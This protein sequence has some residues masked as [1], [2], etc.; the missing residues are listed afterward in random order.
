MILLYYFN[1]GAK[2][3]RYKL[4]F[5]ILVAVLIFHV[6]PTAP[7]S[8]LDPGEPAGKIWV[9]KDRKFGTPVMTSYK[10]EA[11]YTGNGTWVH[12]WSNVYNKK[13]GLF[14]ITLGES[15][16]RVYQREV[17]TPYT[18][19]VPIWEDIAEFT[20]DTP[21]AVLAPGDKVA[22][23]LKGKLSGKPQAVA[24]FQCTVKAEL[25]TKDNKL[26]STVRS[27]SVD[28]STASRQDSES[29]QFTVPL[30]SD[31]RL[32]ITA[33]T[34]YVSGGEIKW[35]Y[36]P[37]ASASDSNRDRIVDPRLPI[38]HI[39]AH[40]SI[41]QPGVMIR[42]SDDTDWKPALDAMLIKKGDTVRTAS[43]GKAIIIYQGN[44]GG[45]GALSIGSDTEINIDEF[46]AMEQ[47]GMPAF[48]S[49]IT[50]KKYNGLMTL[51]KGTLR[52]I[53]KGWKSSSIFS[54]KAGTTLCGG[55]RGCD[56]I[57]RYMPDYDGLQMFVREGSVAL[58]SNKTNTEKNLNSG[59]WIN[60][61]NG[62][63]EE[64]QNLNDD[65][66]DT[67]VRSTRM[68]IDETKL[69]AKTSSFS[70]LNII[71]ITASSVVGLLIIALAVFFG[72]RILRKKG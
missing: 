23:Q 59:Q 34:D 60:A 16:I 62:K 64:I 21:P 11:A 41:S 14:E 38:E 54:V 8:A 57:V 2:R 6:L 70:V 72:I 45:Y 1:K 35:I 44:D 43:G 61:I 32:I 26:K 52:W 49:G 65:A 42:G 7:V 13:T 48:L 3:L 47:E 56:V 24:K 28:I 30:T 53:T 5:L 37:G 31:D 17:N 40:I 10:K 22:L 25:W 4:L 50:G 51:I 36:E 29:V 58:T 63:F 55:I 12:R 68:E 33:S 19:D 9:L 20:F 15:G 27:G 66:W 39:P 71:L 67:A 69:P 18:G 46:T